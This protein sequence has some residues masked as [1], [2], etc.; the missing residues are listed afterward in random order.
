MRFLSPL[1]LLALA[2]CI[3]APPAQ[4]QQEL[5]LTAD[6]ILALLATNPYFKDSK[7][8]P[9]P[10]AGTRALVIAAS[11]PAGQPPMTV[12]IY[13]D[14]NNISGIS[15]RYDPR[16]MDVGVFAAF[17]ELIR[18]ALPEFGSPP[19]SSAKSIIGDDVPEAFRWPYQLKDELTQLAGS[20]N[21]PYLLRRAGGRY[22]FLMHGT[23]SETIAVLGRGAVADLSGAQP[24][25]EP[26]VGQ[27]LA[28]AEAGH[29]DEALAS[30]RTLAES[31]SADAQAWLAEYLVMRRGVAFK[32]EEAEAREKSI[33]A[34]LQASA[35][36]GNA[37]AQFWLG[38]LARHRFANLAQADAPEWFRKAA[39]QGH[40]GAQFERAFD[41]V[42]G[43]GA[44][45]VESTR[46]FEVAALQGNWGAMI[47]IA[48]QLRKGH[49]RAADAKR[50]F[51]WYRI[52][53]TRLPRF[54]GVNPA[55]MLRM[56]GKVA[57]ELEA[58]EKQEIEREVAQWKPLAWADIRRAC[59]RILC[60]MDL[61]R[62]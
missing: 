16:T 30:L 24:P 52:F 41:L 6:R 15:V 34:A 12:E 28:R 22:L 3:F 5:G 48:E 62:P 53:E 58:A 11:E 10:E 39:L 43:P 42:S 59:G 31:G 47:G 56:S 37:H 19:A 14:R 50:A 17:G 26:A 54:P 29:Y 38:R 13:G 8:E 1:R 20:F 44:D 23:D 61:T 27:A 60:P 46:W 49:G 32:L 36:K 7:L 2:V 40:A 45:A 35:A 25:I 18:L 21:T 9:H 57:D 51:Y 55:S 4:A 33:M